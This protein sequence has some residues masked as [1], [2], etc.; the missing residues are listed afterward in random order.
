MKFVYILILNIAFTYGDDFN[1]NLASQ[2]LIKSNTVK[3]KFKNIQKGKFRFW[4]T[5]DCLSIL[6]ENSPFVIREGCYFQN[7]QAPYG[8]ILL[9]PHKNEVIDRYYGFPVS[10][11]N[12]SAT[13]HMKSNEVIILLG[14]T[15]PECKYFG[16]SNYLYSRHFPE[17]WSPTNVNSKINLNC[18]NGTESDRCEIFS[19]LDDSL[20]LDRGLNLNKKNKFNSSFTI[21][22]SQSMEATNYAIKSLI[23]SGVP[24]NLISNYSFP[25]NE[26]KLGINTKDDTFITI[27]RTAYYQNISDANNYFNNIPY[28]VYR[29][30]LDKDDVTLYS[31]TK[32]INRKTNYNDASLIGISLFELDNNLKKLVYSVINNLNKQENIDIQVTQTKSGVPDHGFE[33][34]NN[35]TRCLADCR[36]TV[37]PFSTKMY[38]LS[39][40]CEV[41]PD[42]CYRNMNGILSNDVNDAIIVI[43]IN[44]AMTQMSTY[45][46][47]SIYDSKYLWGVY[48]VGNNQLENTAYKYINDTIDSSLNISLPYMYVF[49]FRRNCSNIH[50]C[51]SIPNYPSNNDSFIPLSNPVSITERMYNNPITHVGPYYKDIIMPYVIHTRSSPK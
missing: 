31:R 3:T 26:L 36:D 21:V 17:D 8:L 20:N 47:V 44:H 48:S 16:F 43:G 51:L 34:I 33:C 27:L 23:E 39:E 12:L 35:G 4:Q 46:S 32:L 42:N 41:S 13:W 10:D 1:Y 28:V 7:P 14:K 6:Y 37:Y 18:P 5:T 25:G 45:S 22:F 24:K 30:E 11:G 9:P 15:P 49:E 50:N 38:K 40:F 29:M 2:K 19:S